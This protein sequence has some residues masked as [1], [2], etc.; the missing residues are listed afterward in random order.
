MLSRGLEGK[1]KGK[2]RKGK[3]KERKEERK[4]ETKEKQKT[5]KKELFLVFLDSLHKALTTLRGSGKQA[6][7][8]SGTRAQGVGKS[9]EEKREGQ[10][11][12]ALC[13]KGKKKKKKK[14]C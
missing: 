9:E 6:P 11:M 5:Q 14:V 2:R 8:G 1:R 3:E 12:G 13:T 4:E 7:A 10:K